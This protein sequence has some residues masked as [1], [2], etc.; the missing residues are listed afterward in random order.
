MSDSGFSGTR[1]VPPPVNEPVKAYA[2]G[3]PI[4]LSFRAPSSTFPC[5]SATLPLCDSATLPLFY[6]VCSM[7]DFVEIDGVKLFLGR[8]DQ[9][10][11][12]WIG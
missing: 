9:S 8:P 2:P 12:D 6:P 7:P 11:G 10:P 3:S 1:R 5:N 4:V